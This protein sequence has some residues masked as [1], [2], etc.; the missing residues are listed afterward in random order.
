MNPR[1]LPNILTMAKHICSSEARRVFV[2]F[3]SPE[4]QPR[5]GLIMNFNVKELGRCLDKIPS[6]QKQ[7]IVWKAEHFSMI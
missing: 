6:M 2:D 4:D 5:S 3:G 7:V 1:R